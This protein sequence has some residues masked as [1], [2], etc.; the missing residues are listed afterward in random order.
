MFKALPPTIPGSANFNNLFVKNFL[1]LNRGG[2][3]AFAQIIP[4]LLVLPQVLTVVLDN[5]QVQLDV[6]AVG[7]PTD[8]G[9]IGRVI[10]YDLE[11]GQ[12]ILNNIILPTGHTTPPKFGSSISLSTDANTLVIGGPGDTTN[13]GAIWIYI[14]TNGVWSL[15]QGPL[16]GS[17]GVAA[18]QGESVSIYGDTIVVGGSTDASGLGAVWVFF[19]TDGVWSQQGPKLFP[20]NSIGSFIQFGIRV[21]LYEDT[22]VASGFGDNNFLGAVWVYTRSGTTW[23]Q[24]QKII[25]D[26]PA[27]TGLQYGSSLGFNGNTIAISSNG[28]GDLPLNGNIPVN[29]YENI[30]NV[31]TKVAS[32]GQSQVG[33]LNISINE[34]YIIISTKVN[35]SIIILQKIQ[36]WKIIQIID[37]DI[38][39]GGGFPTSAPISISNDNRLCFILS[40]DK[41]VSTFN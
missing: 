39:S 29:I 13:V 40:G 14:R 5:I 35:G 21:S 26:S 15:Q 31:W 37:K 4:N 24:S 16:V 12:W 2:G 36:D 10:L 8:N 30:G 7:E 9:N 32:F 28:V 41:I 25:P 18:K 6:L 38:G 19:R 20:N 22:F 17:G 34:T 1:A 3:D 23:A 27:T 33:A 11:N